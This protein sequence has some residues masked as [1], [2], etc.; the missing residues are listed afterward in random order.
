MQQNA[1][2]LNIMA[3]SLQRLQIYIKF[4]KLFAMIT[5]LIIS[6]GKKKIRSLTRK[7]YPTVKTVSNEEEE[8]KEK[9]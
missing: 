6:E 8:R 1:H 4:I 9:K 3:A 2:K 5:K 7:Y